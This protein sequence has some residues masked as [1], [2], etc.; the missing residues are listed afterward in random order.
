MGIDISRNNGSCFF[1]S[2]YDYCYNDV[3]CYHYSGVHDYIK[4]MKCGYGKVTDHVSR[5]I[6][7][8]R[9]TRSQGIAL[10]TKYFNYNN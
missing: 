3:D 10:I 2:G 9:L 8:K 5:E 1:F 7:L 6:R 4:L